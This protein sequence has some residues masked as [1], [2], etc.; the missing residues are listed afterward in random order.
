VLL[1]LAT[2]L[3]SE[4]APELAKRLGG[5]YSYMQQRLLEAN[6]RQQDAPLADVLSL[7]TT[8]AEAWKAV[9]DV[10]AVPDEPAPV[11]RKNGWAGARID[12][13]P[14]RLALSA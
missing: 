7:L 4:Q 11:A 2:S 5:L 12:D 9:P 1:E 13:E 6:L 3:D 14:V 10:P 8:L